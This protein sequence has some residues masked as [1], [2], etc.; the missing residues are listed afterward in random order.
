M[1][2]SSRIIE[3]HLSGSASRVASRRETVSRGG[4]YVPPIPTLLSGPEV[5]PALNTAVIFWELDPSNSAGYHR[6]RYREGESGA[7]TYTAYTVE[8]SHSAEVTISGLTGEHTL[9]SYQVQSCET[10]TGGVGSNCMDYAPDPQDTFYTT[11]SIPQQSGHCAMWVNFILGNRFKVT[12]NIAGSVRVRYKVVG[13]GDWT[14]CDWSVV[15][16]ARTWSISPCSGTGV[17]VNYEFQFEFKNKCGTS[18]GWSATHNVSTDA[19]NKFIS[20][21]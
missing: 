10:V 20:T 2:V 14:T 13:V 3:P 11:C 8:A 6:A 1:S 19:F 12:T 21:C 5:V 15:G 9:H 18:T 4:L 17:S 16:S 7:W